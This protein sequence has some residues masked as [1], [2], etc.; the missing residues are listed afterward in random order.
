MWLAESSYGRNGPIHK[1]D[2]AEFWAWPYREVLSLDITKL[3]ILDEI[4][5]AYWHDYRKKCGQPGDSLR[6][7]Y[8]RFAWVDEPAKKL[9]RTARVLM[10]YHAECGRRD[11]M[12]TFRIKL[13]RLNVPHNIIIFHEGEG[14]LEFSCP[15]LECG[16]EHSRDLV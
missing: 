4:V 14:Q 13:C 3:R 10:V 9:E 15:R 5:F 16:D 11:L 12:I 6:L 1:K 2:L 8:F 7:L